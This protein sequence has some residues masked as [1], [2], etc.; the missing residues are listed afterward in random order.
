MPH[1]AL[2]A[3]ALGIRSADVSR[4]TDTKPHRKW[5]LPT[6]VIAAPDRDVE[7]SE[8]QFKV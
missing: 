6:A 1:P 2:K 3:A 7:A 4:T 5:V 8:V